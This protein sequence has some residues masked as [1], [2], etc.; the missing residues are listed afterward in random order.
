MEEEK[1]EGTKTVPPPPTIPPP[2]QNRATPKLL[3]EKP[4][5]LDYQ[6]TRK[7]R[8]DWKDWHHGN[9]WLRWRMEG[10]KPGQEREEKIEEREKLGCKRII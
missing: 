7:R 2:L 6:A 1:E 5:R 8:N 4:L 9:D 10:M 3:E